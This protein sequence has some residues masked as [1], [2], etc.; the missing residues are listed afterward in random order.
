[1]KNLGSDKISLTPSS[2]FPNASFSPETLELNSGEEKE[3]SLGVKGISENQTVNLFLSAGEKTYAIESRALSMP[4]GSA[5]T[6]FFTASRTI[7][8]FALVVFVAIIALA[9]VLKKEFEEQKTLDVEKESESE[10]PK[11]AEKEKKK[12]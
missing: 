2:D 4:S 11:K 3:L 5:G 8:L 10:E 12:K 9:F 7:G 6:G 1:M